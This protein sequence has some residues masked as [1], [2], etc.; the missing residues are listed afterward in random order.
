MELP[1]LSVA[2]SLTEFAV[3]VLG[4]LV[5]LGFESWR[6][7]VAERELELEYLERLQSEF[8][9]DAERIATAVRANPIQQTHI[10]AALLVLDE[11]GTNTNQDLLSVFM[12]SRSV[13]SR[14]I[15][16]TFRDLLGTGELHLVHNTALRDRLLSFYSWIGVAIITAPGLDD[17]L[18]YRH[19]VRGEIS[20][21]L[22]KALRACGGAQARTLAL[23]DLNM[24]TDCDYGASEDEVISILAGIRANP[25][26]L[27]ALRR[28]AAAFSALGDRLDAVQTRTNELEFLIA[29]EIAQH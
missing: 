29:E 8:H 12:A 4:V 16:A 2:R 14:Q 25:E 15:G 3:I 21:R 10:N 24:V 23:P 19:I 9:V 22:Q 7:D 20:P 27:P 6:E 17:R 11:G 28:W 5:A 18:A 13:W 26:T 1:K